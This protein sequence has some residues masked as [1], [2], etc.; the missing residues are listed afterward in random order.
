VDLAGQASTRSLGV[1]LLALA[2]AC[3]GSSTG[4]VDARPAP[5]D[6]SDTPDASA[7]DGPSSVDAT[8]AD[9]PGAPDGAL[10]ADAAP[11]AAAPDAGIP[12]GDLDGDGLDNAW[13]VAAGDTSLLDWHVSDSD[14][15]GIDD[16]DED[17]DGDGLTNLEELALARLTSSPAGTAPHPFRVDLPV[18]LDAMTD[19]V[20]SDGVLADAAAA[21]EALPIDGAAGWSGVGLLFYRDEEDIAPTDFADNDALLS[22]LGAHGPAFTDFDDPPV[23]YDE[24]VHIA[25]V[26]VR[27]STPNT[28]ATTVFYGSGGEVEDTG[29]AV[30]FDAIAATHPACAGDIS[31]HAAQVAALVHELGH[32]LQLGHDTD[33]GG[34]VNFYNVMAICA[35][36][37]EAAM[38]FLG[39]GNS[40]ETLGNTAAIASSRFSWAA[41]AL[42]D[43]SNKLSVDT[44]AMVD[45][46]GVE[47]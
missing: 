11:D 23:P 16:G 3:G 46:D 17:Y 32:I 40:D 5:P 34:G 47:M 15:D 6:A 30:F 35:T 33:V 9:A 39:T 21:F 14:D 37:P 8:E 31:V 26:T 2:A 22:F 12:A 4:D 1:A 38:R 42:M 36:C 10:P 25:V 24:L 43:F 27:T 44:A 41:A 45:V 28:P 7:T 20:L 18:E 13:E 19:R 29:A